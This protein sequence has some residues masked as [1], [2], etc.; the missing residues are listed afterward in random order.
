MAQSCCSLAS[1]DGSKV[2]SRAFKGGGSLG[3]LA[4]QDHRHVVSQLGT[5]VLL[6]ATVCIALCCFADC[7]LGGLPWLCWS[8]TQLKG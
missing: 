5:L 8:V 2:Q 7:C 3:Y 6:L 4:T 1:V